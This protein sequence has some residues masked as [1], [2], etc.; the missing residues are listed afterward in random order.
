M[1]VAKAAEML[2]WEGYGP[3]NLLFSPKKS[4]SGYIRFYLNSRGN[5]FLFSSLQIPENWY[6]TCT[7]VFGILLV[8]KSKFFLDR[9]GGSGTGEA[10]P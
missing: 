7:S 3:K 9:G 6:I 1:R 8:P 2:I 5:F 10:E 4:G